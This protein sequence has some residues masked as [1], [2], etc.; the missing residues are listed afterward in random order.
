MS[1]RSRVLLLSNGHGE[2]TVG[3]QLALELRRRYPQLE[4]SAYPTVGEGRPYCAAGVRLAG[5]HRALPSGGLLLHSRQLFLGDVR[6]GL[7]GKTLR[8]VWEL[9]RLEP[10][11]IITVGDAYALLLSA[12][13]KAKRRFF[14]Q[15][16]VSA[17]HAQSARTRA[18]RRFME[19][20]DSLEL[21]LMRRFA[22]QVYVRDEATAKLLHMLDIE[23]TRY[24]GNPMLDQVTGGCALK[25]HKQSKQPVVAMLPGTRAYKYRALEVMMAA[26]REL[27]SGTGLLAWTGG[28]LPLF[29]GWTRA[30]AKGNG[31]SYIYRHSGKEVFVYE[32]RFA[33]ILH[34]AQLVLGTSGT[35]NEQ[36]AALGKPVVAFAVPPFYSAAFLENQKRLLAEALVIVNRHPKTLAAAMWALHSE[37]ERYEKAARAGQQRMGEAGGS[38]AIIGDIANQLVPF[39]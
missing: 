28:I 37:P 39:P 25:R 32:N 10:D 29:S 36:A 24:L 18:N 27:P 2:D 4:L 15:T 26:F 3:A 19:R 31:L 30:E 8:Q 16:L 33:D 22:E 17:H 11:I 23:H 9:G 5:T 35:A 13:V 7:L 34:T 14:V 6:A 21:S 38:A 1:K 12:R 20:F